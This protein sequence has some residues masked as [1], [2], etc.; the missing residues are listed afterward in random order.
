[1]FGRMQH[2]INEAFFDQLSRLE[3]NAFLQALYDKG[4][5]V[6]EIAKKIRKSEQTIYRRI[7]A[8]RGRGAAY[9]IPA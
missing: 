9:N 3:Q 8:H 2:D 7:N 4:Y 1:M 5:N 6:P